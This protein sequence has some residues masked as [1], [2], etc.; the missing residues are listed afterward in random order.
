MKK[1]DILRIMA[2]VVYPSFDDA[3]AAIDTANELY[4]HYNV[5][6]PTSPEYEKGMDREYEMKR[7]SVD[8]LIAKFKELHDNS[9]LKP[10]M[11]TYDEQGDN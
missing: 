8:S 6:D 9:D 1:A 5:C 11:L 3:S 4:D 2:A 7:D 10:G